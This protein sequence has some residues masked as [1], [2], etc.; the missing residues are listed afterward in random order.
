MLTITLQAY[1]IVPIIITIITIIAICM[2]IY[3]IAMDGYINV[4]DVKSLLILW[5]IFMTVS[6]ASIVSS[7][8]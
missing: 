2:L 1:H 4:G 3:S 8:V 5:A 7:L 6:V